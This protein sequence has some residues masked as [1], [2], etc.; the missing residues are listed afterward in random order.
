MRT[1]PNVPWRAL[2]GAALALIASSALAGEITLYQHRDFNGSTLTVSRAAPDLERTGF[3][4]TAASIVVREGVWEVCTDPFYRGNCTRL[5]PGE[6][7]RLEPALRDRVASV[8]E[9]VGVSVAPPPVVVPAPVVTVPAPVV[10]SADARIVLFEQP[11]LAGRAVELRVT[12]GKLDRIPAYSGA[13]AAIVYGGTW[14]LCTRDYYRG[15][16]AD[17]GPGRYDSLGA[18]NGRISSAELVSPGPAPVG[19]ITTPVPAEGRVVLYELPD[20]GGQSLVIDRRE[21]PNLESMGFMDRAASMR[22]DAGT[23][24]VCTDTR[25]QGQCRTFGPGEYPRLTRDV[26]RRIASV[27]RVNDVY[28]AASLSKQSYASAT[29]SKKQY[30]ISY[31]D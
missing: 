17:F 3:N 28:G 1:E 10:A 29:P 15:Q 26:D 31:V 12:N 23:W 16:C 19:V 4:D 7:T 20:F 30:A 14:R 13:G 21:L 2:V 18:L 22:V 11:G 9:I 5:Q 27:R 25:F 6:Y 8:R 24:M